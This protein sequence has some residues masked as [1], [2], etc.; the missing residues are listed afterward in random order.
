M[1]RNLFLLLFCIGNFAFSQNLEDTIYLATEKFIAN[2]SLESLEE[3]SE[4]EINFKNKISTKDEQLAFI[5]L[6]CNKAY[7]LKDLNRFNPA[8]TSYETAWTYYNENQLVN[9]SDYDII[10]YCLKPLGNLYTKTNNYTDAENTIKQY[11]SIAEKK[12]DKVQYVAGIINLSVLYQT[13]GMH[14]LVVDLINQSLEVLKIDSKQ[15]DKLN[16]LKASS[17]IALNTSKNYN[18]EN[19]II[20]SVSDGQYNKHLLQYELALKNGDYTSALEHFNMSTLIQEKDSLTKREIAKNYLKKGQLEYLLNNFDKANQSLQS[21]LHMFL[22]NLEEKTIPEKSTLYAENTFIDIFDLLARL[23]IH[24]ETALIY[25]D[26]SFYV[27]NLLTENLTSQ[28]SKIANQVSNRNRSEHCI[29]L[30]FQTYQKNSDTKIFTRAL[31]YTETYKASVLKG[32]FQKKSLL[33]LHPNDGL[34]IKEQKLLQQQEQLT[35]LLIKTQLGYQTSTNDSL[36]KQ[37]LNLSIDLKNL[38]SDIELKYPQTENNID[39]TGIQKQLQVDK[40]NLIIYFYGKQAIYQFIISEKNTSFL[41]IDLTDAV[42]NS[43]TNF[44]H[45][46]DS[47]S[48]IN[49]NIK[50]FSNQAYNL[51]Q[52]LHL[53]D[54]SNSKNLIIIPD[55]LLNFIPFE[56]LLTKKTESSNFSE[57]SFLVSQHAVGYNSSLEFYLQPKIPSKNTNLLGVFPVFENS[58]QMLGYSVDEAL[59]IKEETNGTILMHAEA[60]KQNFMDLAVKYGVLHLSTHATGGDFTNPASMAFYDEPMLLNELYSL[61]INPELVVLSACETGIGKLQK[62]EGAMSIARGFQYAGAKNILYSL[63]QINDASTAK[64]MT[65]FY[66]NYQSIN[67]AF[68]ANRQSKLDYLNDKSISNIKKSP[69]YWSAF[70]YYGDLV[71]KKDSNQ[72]MYYILGV[73]VVLIIVFLF[74]RK[75]KHHD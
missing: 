30:L 18:L 33:E 22:P 51:Y 20:F 21:A 54:I 66:K 74:F 9:I 41:K 50:N 38:H 7:Y 12:K 16:T 31:A 55:G 10:E 63:W 13:R 28:E 27:S 62:G 60:T 17:L 42:K 3:L 57:M 61:N 71:P 48:A 43:L 73:L 11:L 46:F 36:N 39:V 44:I 67:S 45:L 8:I 59:A 2:K 4:Q 29:E 25:Y 69:Y 65:L 72:I 26:L 14:Q 70:V 52:L 15:K 49:N 37:L 23:Q 5:F 6:L 68:V 58:N 35:D 1:K 75:Q 56:A 24:P 34:L 53:E 47:P 64:L 32:V 19:D 40:T